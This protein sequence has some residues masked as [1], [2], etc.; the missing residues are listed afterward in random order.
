[1]WTK[2]DLHKLNS[3]ARTLRE[4]I[5]KARTTVNNGVLK[6]NIGKL[7]LME[8]IRNEMV[9]GKPKFSNETKRKTEFDR[10]INGGHHLRDLDL[11]LKDDEYK[12][13]IKEIELSFLNRQLDI[14]LKFFT[15]Q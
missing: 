3:S 9:E 8:D 14:E 12:I 6:Y 4:H 2:E 1:M 10:L 7:N 5:L 15:E 11:R 13:K